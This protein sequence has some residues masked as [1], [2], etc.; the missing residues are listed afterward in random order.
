MAGSIPAVSARASR[1]R[2]SRVPILWVCLAGLLSL[3]AYLAV[4][5]NEAS[6]DTISHTLTA[7]SIL[8]GR[9]TSFAPEV[10]DLPAWQHA[11]T[12]YFVENR[13]GDWASGYGLGVPLA[14][15][16][17]YAPLKALGVPETLLYSIGFNHLV[18]A[19][20]MALAVGF[21]LLAVR[22][23]VPMRAALIATTALALG[24]SALPLLSREL[25]QQ[26]L[27]SLLYAVALWLLV[28]SLEG[29][30]HTRALLLGLGLVLGWTVA[31]RPTALLYLLAWLVAAAVLHRQR[32]A[33]LAPPLALW[34]LI[35]LS[36][37]HAVWG[38]PFQSGQA[39]I[40]AG[41]F[42]GMARG[43]LNPDPLAGLAG[44]LVSPGAGLLFYSPVLLVGFALMPLLWRRG[45]GVHRT[46]RVIGA[47]AAVTVT[48]D[49][50]ATALYREWWAGSVYGY[51]YMSDTVVLACFLLAA[52]LAAAAS[53]PRARRLA[54]HTATVLL[55]LLSVAIQGIGLLVN[56]Y[57]PESYNAAFSIDR[58]PERLWSLRHSPPLH[59][60]RQWAARNVRGGDDRP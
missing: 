56:P 17:V 58:H 1:T 60:L 44:A 10:L 11:P 5:L 32:A 23:L 18:A 47:L 26:T 37:N 55:L 48:L 29:T 6:G 12:V 49:L 42:G 9:W 38:D 14:L 4:P 13:H 33:W 53:L 25:W 31:V 41:R 46:A 20:W 15:L 59:N 45:N 7:A 51:R 39:L 30:P 36:Y 52:G 54:V 22:R 19:T 24:T 50:V 16:P 3:L 27:L 34:A 35:T 21:F 8:H 2:T 57:S 28:R 43:L 40:P